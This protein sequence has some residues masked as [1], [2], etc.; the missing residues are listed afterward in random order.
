MRICLFVLFLATTGSIELKLALKLQMV[1]MG[2]EEPTL[3]SEVIIILRLRAKERV[4]V[5][6]SLSSDAFHMCCEGDV[7][8]ESNAGR[9]KTPES[10][11]LALYGRSLTLGCF[12]S[13]AGHGGLKPPS[14]R[15]V[16][17][18]N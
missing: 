14:L 3:G 6:R 1:Q 8:Q 5:L 11:H 9:D 2:Q 17:A 12:V 16:C 18:V 7:E 4:S 10:P 13:R 15:S